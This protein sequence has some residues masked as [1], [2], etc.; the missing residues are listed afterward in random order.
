MTTAI[1]NR[2]TTDL[3]EITRTSS[4]APWP[5][6]PPPPNAQ[7]VATVIDRVANTYLSLRSD[8]RRFLIDDGFAC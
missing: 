6:A 3:G 1:E 7:S 2:V 4:A 8:R 5:E